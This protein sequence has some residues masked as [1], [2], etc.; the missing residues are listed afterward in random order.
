MDF[1]PEF[2]EDY[3]D[4]LEKRFK[5]SFGSDV[6]DDYHCYLHLKD[7]LKSIMIE[8]F[9]DNKDGYETV[10]KYLKNDM[11]RWKKD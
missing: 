5:P 8:L 3:I 7:K 2:A 4:A 11:E 6:W 10:I 9:V 1:D